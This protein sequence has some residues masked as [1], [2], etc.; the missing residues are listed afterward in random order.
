MNQII[1]RRPS[2]LM[3]AGR[4][5]KI[6][7]DGKIVGNIGNNEVKQFETPSIAFKL[8]TKV[9]FNESKAIELK[10]G[11]P[12]DYTIKQNLISTIATIGMSICFATYFVINNFEKSDNKLLVY[13]GIPF[14]IV[15]LYFSTFGR[16]NVIKIL[17]TEE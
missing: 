10:E 14:L 9:M 15:N 4:N 2:N 8:T 17:K 13:I 11:Q 5:F 6:L 7:I 16:K 3:L 12:G 1:I